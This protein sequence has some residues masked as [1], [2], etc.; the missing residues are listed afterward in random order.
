M[1]KGID[2]PI[3]SLVSLFNSYLWTNTT[4]KTFYGRVFRNERFESFQ[5]KISPEIYTSSTDYIEVLKN[6]NLDAQCFFDVQPT[7]D[8]QKSDFHTANVWVVFMIDLSKV[9][10]L[11]T[12]Q[13]ATEE[14]HREVELLLLDS[15]FELKGNSLV[16]GFNAVIDY[17]WGENSDQARTDMYPHYCFRFEG[18][19]DYQ[20]SNCS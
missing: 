20:L 4:N 9:Y 3:D 10:P 18:T 17:D 13:E 12:R 7:G 19:I 5:S 8:S 6:D 15:K 1:S 14:A 11:L 16:R 2:I